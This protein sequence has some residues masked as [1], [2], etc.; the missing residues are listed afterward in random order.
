MGFT[1][2]RLGESKDADFEAYARLLRQRGKNL[3]NL[4]RTPDPA[5]PGRRWVHVWDNQTDAEDFARDIHEETGDSGWSVVPIDEPASNGPLGPVVFQLVRRSDGLSLT[6]HPLSRVTIQQACRSSA[7]SVS[8]AFVNLETWREFEDLRGNLG[9]LVETIAPALSGLSPN[10]LRD[11]G[12]MVI[13]ADTDRTS[14]HVPPA[15]LIA[16]HV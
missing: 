6:L 15:G 11:I 5:N 4:P 10:E 12:Y 7:P 9:D 8:N 14:I 13:D 16:A 2:T 1:V 3:G